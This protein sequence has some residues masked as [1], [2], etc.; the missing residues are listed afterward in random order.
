MGKGM[1]TLYKTLISGTDLVSE[2]FMGA[3][4]DLV[5]AD[6]PVLI[7]VNPD[8]KAKASH[9]TRAAFLHTEPETVRHICVR[10]DDGNDPCIMEVDGGC[11]AGTQLLTEESHLGYFLVFLPGYTADTVQTNMELAELLLAQ[12]QLICGLIEKNNKFHHMQLMNLTRRS[13]IL[14]ASPAAAVV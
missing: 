12:A 10:I 5:D 8:F 1:E 13:A 4:F 11:V 3:V 9:P 7:Y 2:Q 14:G 6:G